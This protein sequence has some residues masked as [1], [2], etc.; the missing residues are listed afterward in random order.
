MRL[1]C[2]FTIANNLSLG[3]A[4]KAEQ[5]LDWK[6]EFDTLDKLIDDMFS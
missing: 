5:E 1:S 2:S 4:T 6:R 3:D